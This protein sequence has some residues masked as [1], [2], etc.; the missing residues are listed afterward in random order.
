MPLPISTISCGRC[1][2]LSFLG[3][4]KLEFD[5]HGLKYSGETG[6]FCISLL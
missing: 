5:T 6:Q 4:S 3:W 1:C 2:A